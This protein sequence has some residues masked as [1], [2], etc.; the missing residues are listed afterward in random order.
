[1]SASFT[2][3]TKRAHCDSRMSQ[4]TKVEKF[5]LISP[6]PRYASVNL[7]QGLGLAKSSWRAPQPMIMAYAMTTCVWRRLPRIPLTK[8]S[9]KPPWPPK[10]MSSTSPFSCGILLDC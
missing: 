1:M 4:M 7:D 3:Q 10:W 5:V 2:I 6:F 8:T 9:Y